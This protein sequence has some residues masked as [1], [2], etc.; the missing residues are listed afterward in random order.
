[1]SHNESSRLNLDGFNSKPFELFEN[2][3]VNNDNKFKNLTGTF[4]ESGVSK[5]YF[6]QENLDYLQ[7][8]IISRIYEKTQQKHV[9]GRQSDDELLIVMRGTYLQF[10]KNASNDIDGQIDNLNELVLEYCVDN[11]Y[12]NLLQYFEYMNDITKDQCVLDHPETTH[13]KGSKSLMPNL[14]F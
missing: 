12:T 3:N 9:V 6:S 13:I 2:L 8:Q 7:T 11:V 5:L 10:C 1:M 14:F 4:S